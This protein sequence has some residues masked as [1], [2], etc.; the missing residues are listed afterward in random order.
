[1]PDAQARGVRA[2]LLANQTGIGKTFDG[3]GFLNEA[4]PSRAT[5]RQS[6]PGWSSTPISRAMTTAAL[7]RTATRRPVGVAPIEQCPPSGVGVEAER[8]AAGRESQPCRRTLDPVTRCAPIG[9]GS[10]ARVAQIAQR[11]QQDFAEQHAALLGAERRCR[12]LRERSAATAAWYTS[13]NGTPRS[14]ARAVHDSYSGATLSTPPGAR[15]TL[16]ARCLGWRAA[17][18]PQT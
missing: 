15:A 12:Y 6:R 5:A 10:R 3:I 7:P 16:T 9:G 1:M 14:R 8:L 13:F 4:K 11:R 2:F 18:N 17:S